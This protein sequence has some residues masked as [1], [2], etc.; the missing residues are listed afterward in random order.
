MDN[1]KSFVLGVVWSEVNR[2][3][4]S[5]YYNVE[6]DIPENDMLPG[7]ITLSWKGSWALDVPP[8]YRGYVPG[9]SDHP[10]VVCYEVVRTVESMR[11]YFERNLWFLRRG[12]E[13]VLK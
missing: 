6:V 8:V 12:W 13:S 2:W 7:I 4:H 11:G 5:E 9:A 1:M 10:Y 3:K